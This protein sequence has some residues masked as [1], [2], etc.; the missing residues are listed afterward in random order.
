MKKLKFLFLSG[1]AILS[2]APL[3]VSCGADE[4]KPADKQIIFATAQG[5]T[6]PLMVALK[7]MIEYYNRTFFE[8]PDFIPVSLHTQTQTQTYSELRLITDTITNIDANS[9]NIPNIILSNQ[10]GAY[11]MKSRGK[12]LDLKENGLNIRF[13]Q[14]IQDSHS[15]LAGQSLD[16]KQLFNV[17][18]DIADTDSVVFNLDIMNK[19]FELIKSNGGKVDDFDLV[20]KAKAAS[21]TGSDIPKRS[22]FYALK[23]KSSS[24][25]DGYH[26]TEDTFKTFKG[27]RNF[28]KKV[29]D[30]TDFDQ[31]KTGELKLSANVLSI[32]YQ[33]DVFRKE[34]QS[35]TKDSQRLWNLETTSDANQPTK[36]NFEN[37]KNSESEASKTFVKLWNE[38]KAALAERKVKEGGTN[39]IRFQS[40]QFKKNENADWGS[41]DI[42]KYSSAISYAA[43]VGSNATQQSYLS[44]A[45]FLSG[46]QEPEET[47]EYKS[48]ASH[49]DVFMK[50]QLLLAKENANKAYWEG[51]SSIVAIQSSDEDLNKGTSKFLN[52][53][54][55]G[56]VIGR[57]TFEEDEEVPNWMKIAELSGY[58]LPSE[59]AVTQENLDKMIASRDQLISDWRKQLKAFK[60]RIASGESFIS[61]KRESI[62]LSIDEKLIKANRLNSAIVTLE[63]LLKYTNNDDVK[64]ANNVGDYNTAVLVDI[65]K[66]DLLNLN[67]PTKESNVFESST[68]GEEQLAKFQRLVRKL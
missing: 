66:D 61:G 20:Q 5:D 35:L 29:Y 49:D 21:E 30:A 56:T 57:K 12:L 19:L 42:R 9:E 51:G 23:A 28:A 11:L 53:L 44:V 68:T 26:V 8:D 22:P 58:I 15:I 7:P 14:K 54:Y 1:S 18:F 65:L 17:P 10:T 25:F 31:E 40:I 39:D 6:W 47:E 13:S 46:V 24:A 33:E 41:Y 36:I 3:A 32:D 55:T 59:S 16:T 45:Q 4:V 43:S 50:S 52:W 34:L 60:E 2:A 63:S 64:E 48:W 37:L 67:T 38:W 62:K 27:I